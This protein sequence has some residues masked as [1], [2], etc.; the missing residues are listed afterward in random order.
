MKSP[1]PFSPWAFFYSPNTPL[2][3]SCHSPSGGEL[4]S[5]PSIKIL[6]PW[7]SGT[8]GDEGGILVCSFCRTVWLDTFNPPPDSVGTPP[9]V[10]AFAEPRLR[11][12]RIKKFPSCRGELRRRVGHGLIFILLDLSYFITK[13]ILYCGFLSAP[14][15]ARMTLFAAVCTARCRLFF[16]LRSVLVKLSIALVISI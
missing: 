11:W 8:E 13:C 7:G 3:T 12:G 1:R 16:S 14:R 5:R 15:L 10:S 6:P 9:S 4:N 2:G